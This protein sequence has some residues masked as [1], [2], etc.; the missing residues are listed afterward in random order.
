MRAF[1]D[2]FD[3]TAYGYEAY[4]ML[5]HIEPADL[6]FNCQAKNGAYSQFQLIHYSNDQYLELAFGNGVDGDWVENVD[7]F[8]VPA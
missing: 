6:K 5:C 7:L 2:G 8:A 4:P 1:T 3:L